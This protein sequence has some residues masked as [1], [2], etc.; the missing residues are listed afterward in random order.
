[1]GLSTRGGVTPTRLTPDHSL[2]LDNV[3]MLGPREEPR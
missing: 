3:L 2:Q 1:M